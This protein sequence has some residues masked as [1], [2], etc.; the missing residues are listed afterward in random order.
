[1]TL[2]V[3][4]SSLDAS[5][6]QYLVSKV[7]EL[8]NVDVR[9]STEVV[10]LEADT[11]LAGGRA[12]VAREPVSHACRSESLF[13]CIGGVPRTRGA[14]AGWDSRLDDAG[15]I[16]TGADVSASLGA[17]DGWPLARHRCR[18]RRTCPGFFAAGDVRSGSIKRCSAAIGEGSMA[19]ALV[20]QPPRGT[21]CRVMSGRRESAGR[22]EDA[23]AEFAGLA[24]DQQIDAAASALERNGITSL[25]V[26]SGEQARDAVRSILP[27]GAEVFNNTSRTLEA[28]GVAEDIER[29]GLY[30]PLR[31]R[32]YQMD[33]EMQGREMRQLAAA[34]DFVVGSAHAVTE[35]GSLLIASA[36]GS[37]LGPLVSGA[38]HVIL[39][40]GGQK[41]VADVP[42]GLRR[43]YEYCFPL[44][45]RRARGLRRAERSEQHPD[46]QPGGH[47]EPSHRDPGGEPLGF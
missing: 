5:M 35:E 9:T 7:S 44:E 37:Q 36:S 27:I 11:R 30:Q 32:L 6:S 29:S 34:P 47:A 22:R 33:R 23:V 4:G 39:V 41:I 14:R 20:H 31:P 26:D 1:M 42:T 45:D 16:L 40:I 18:S 21:G 10:G 25:V 8:D 12:L 38:G 28:I 43:I 15:F 19:V 17:L 3:R 13:V 46:H 24:S 2:L